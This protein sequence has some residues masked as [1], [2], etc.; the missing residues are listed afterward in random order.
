LAEPVLEFV[1]R[2][3]DLQLHSQQIVPLP[4]DFYSRVA[5]Y[6]ANLKRASNY[7]NSEITH[8]LISKQIELIEGMIRAMVQA[9]ARI[10]TSTN[11]LQQLLL[12]ERYVCEPSAL[13]E[14]RLGAFVKSV[15]SGQPSFLE[16][17][18]RYELGRSVAVRLLKPVTEVVGPDLRRYGPFEPNDLASVPLAN[19]D[20]LVANG[21]AVIIHTRDDG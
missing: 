15:S 19:A 10:A 3:L 17:A 14:K 7:S 13:F 9:R 21:E 5:T 16:L 1:K 11:S 6:S 8:R 12:E 4:Y 2:H 18:Q 20:I